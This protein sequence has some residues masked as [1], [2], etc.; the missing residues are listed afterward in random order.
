MTGF[1]VE[2]AQRLET[3]EAR[4]LRQYVLAAQQAEPDQ[5]ASFLE[6]E[7]GGA[8]FVG[9]GLPMNRAMGLGVGS[10][11]TEANLDAVEIFY[12]GYSVPAQ[13]GVCPHTDHEFL[14]LLAD[15]GYGVTQFFNVLTLD[16][17]T[18]TPRTVDGIE[19]NEVEAGQQDLWCDMVTRG[20]S[21]EPAE[22]VDGLNRR[23]AQLAVRHEGAVQ[24]VANAGVEAVGGGAVWFDGEIAHLYLA[25][26]RP[27]Q[28]GKGV[29]TALVFAR[30]EAALLRACRLATALATPGSP[31]E[32]NL[33]RLGFD[34]A[35][36][37][38]TMTQLRP[39]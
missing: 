15:H 7:S 4:L 21:E 20:F 23:I 12:D 31:S 38:M 36:T 34:V 17:E 32:R 3:S 2:L 33:R 29:H 22:A 28:R 27:E 25:S 5:H 35:Y 8:A 39:A 11:A 10:R 26:T 14:A 1:S 6:F 9:R 18:W 24:V 30:L 37:R 19:V 16:L 13:V